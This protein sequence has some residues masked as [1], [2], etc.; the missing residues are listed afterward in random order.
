MLD[1]KSGGSAGR[2]GRSGPFGRDKKTTRERITNIAY[3]LDNIG[4]NPLNTALPMKTGKPNEKEASRRWYSV[5]LN[6]RILGRTATR[7]A[8]VLRGKHKP[9]FTPNL[10]LGDFVVVVNAEKV[11]LTGNK[12]EDKKYYRHSGYPG[13]IKE[14]SAASLLVKK[15]EMIFREAVR[16]MLPKNILG[17][18][19]LRKLKIYAGAEHPHKAQKPEELK[20]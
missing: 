10:D 7:V 14:I 17:R 4:G 15:P 18:H 12:W 6:G 20:I 13:G 19:Q 3:R 16:R 8:D 11:K 5:D 1:E 9:Q 2:F